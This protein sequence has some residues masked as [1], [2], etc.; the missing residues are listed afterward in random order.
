VRD[1]VGVATRSVR[2]HADERVVM[3]GEIVWS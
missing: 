1:A 2:T 3:H